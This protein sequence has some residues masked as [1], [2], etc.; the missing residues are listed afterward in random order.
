MAAPSSVLAWRIPDTGGAWWAAI[1]GVAQSQTWLKQLSSSSCM[2]QTWSI[3]LKLSFAKGESLCWISPWTK[4]LYY[5][6]VALEKIYRKETPQ[7]PV[8][9]VNVIKEFE[10]NYPNFGFSFKELIHLRHFFFF[11]WILQIWQL[12]LDFEGKAS[13]RN[14]VSQGW[15]Y[16]KQQMQQGQA[17]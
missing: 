3:H 12:N 13:T 9:S 17:K 5:V 4:N 6:Y 7:F 2:K 15:V 16:K 11:F 1:Y 10:C 8:S 14:S